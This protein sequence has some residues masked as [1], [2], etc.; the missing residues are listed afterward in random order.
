MQAVANHGPIPQGEYHMG[1]A[2]HHPTKGPNSMNLSPVNHTAFGR[3]GFMIHGNNLQNNA[4]QG[5]IVMGPAM[6]QQMAQ[7]DDRVLQVVP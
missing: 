3:T 4:S 1:E 5:C 2:Y 6:R 7:S